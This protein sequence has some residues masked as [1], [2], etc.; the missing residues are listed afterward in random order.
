MNR[1]KCIHA[2]SF[3]G[4]SAAGFT[5]LLSLM[6]LAAAASANEANLTRFGPETYALE[7]EIPTNYSAASRAIDGP[8]ELVLH[9][10]GID[11]AWI[12]ING[13]SVVEPQDFSGNG[14]VFIALNL[15]KENTIEVRISGNTNRARTLKLMPRARG[16][17]PNSDYFYQC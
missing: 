12:E 14:E 9:D 8:A 11:N 16:I 6:A 1:V 17:K 4:L 3:L 15:K 5:L 2:T 13:S 10:E 7:Q